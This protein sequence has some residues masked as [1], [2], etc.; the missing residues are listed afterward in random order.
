MKLFYTSLYKEIGNRLRFYI[1]KKDHGHLSLPDQPFL[2]IKV[3][4]DFPCSQV[5]IKMLMK[6][7]LRSAYLVII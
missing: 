2:G 4:N 5:S 3:N 7:L 6:D 1:T